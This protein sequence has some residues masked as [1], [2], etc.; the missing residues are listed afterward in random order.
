MRFLGRFTRSKWVIHRI[1]FSRRRAMV[2]H[3]ELAA[4]MTRAPPQY[5]N[6]RLPRHGGDPN[7][8][9]CSEAQGAIQMPSETDAPIRTPRKRDGIRKS[10]NGPSAGLILNL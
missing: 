3:G 4:S 6:I 8:E 7:L 9:R 10:P 2:R 5:P 1:V